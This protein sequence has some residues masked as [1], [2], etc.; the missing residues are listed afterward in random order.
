MKK[1][2]FDGRKIG[3]IGTENSKASQSYHHI[4]FCTLSLGW[5]NSIIE[6]DSWPNLLSKMSSTYI[7]SERAGDLTAKVRKATLECKGNLVVT[8]AAWSMAL[9]C[10][11]I[12]FSS[13]WAFGNLFLQHCECNLEH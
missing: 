4:D 10:S 12:G 5:R 6:P 13:C 8:T 2:S 11:K 3:I 7:V 9:S 1:D